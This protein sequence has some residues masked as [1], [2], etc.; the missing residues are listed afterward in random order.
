[1]E[2]EGGRRKRE[3]KREGGREGEEEPNIPELLSNVQF[4][5]VAEEAASIE[6]MGMFSSM[7]SLRE[8]ERRANLLPMT[9]TTVSI[10]A[11]LKNGEKKEKG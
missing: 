1:M 8:E 5:I 11:S 9:C 10:N 2:R 7:I 6:T 3:G 4:S